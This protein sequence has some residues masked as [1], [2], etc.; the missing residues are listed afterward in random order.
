[1]L[2][3]DTNVLV[4]III[5]DHPQQA[6]AAVKLLTHENV[7]ISKTVLLETEWV[8]R[9]LYDQTNKNILM[10]FNKLLG[11]NNITIENNHQVIKAL[12]WTALGMDFAD[13]LHLAAS[14]QTNNLVTFDKKFL[15]KANHILGSN[16]VINPD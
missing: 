12:E 4:R 13:A 1:M 10:I 3:V 8:L 2:A 14:Q 6:K 7:F 16:F 15:K 5:N 9:Y 11:L